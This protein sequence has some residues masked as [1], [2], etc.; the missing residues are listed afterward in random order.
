LPATSAA[1]TSNVCD[2]SARPVRLCGLVQAFHEPASRRHWN[3][4]AGSF[5]EKVKLAAVAA[6]G[7][8]G[9]ES[10]VVVGAAVS[11]AN[12]TLDGVSALPAASSARTR[13]V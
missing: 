1:R 11:R 4:A 13:T 8:A 6:V 12:V 2:P 9:F 3:V 5:D 10:I 7:E